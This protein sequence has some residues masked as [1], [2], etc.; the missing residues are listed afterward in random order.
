MKITQKNNRAIID[1][2]GLKIE[3]EN[4]FNVCT[5]SQ[6]FDSKYVS[7]VKNGIWWISKS[8]VPK[9]T[10]IALKEAKGG[11]NEEANSEPE[12]SM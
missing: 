12:K 6:I 4:T 3:V 9:V 11:I 10:A 5:I 8:E 1:F 7:E 2:E